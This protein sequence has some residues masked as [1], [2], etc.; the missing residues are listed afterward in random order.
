MKLFVRKG[1]MDRN[2]KWDVLDFGHDYTI[3]QDV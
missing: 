1:R 3:K 2:F